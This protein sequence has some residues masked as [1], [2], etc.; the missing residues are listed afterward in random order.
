MPEGLSPEQAAFWQAFCQSPGAPVDAARRFHSAFGIGSGSDAGAEAVVSGRKTATSALPSEFLPGKPPVAGSLSLL[1]ASGNRP[2]AIVETV[3]I[4]PLSLDEMDGDFI[5]A[6]GEWEDATA[7][8]QGML[9]WYRSV[10][11]G[12]T[13]KTKL[14]AERFR[15][16]WTK[17]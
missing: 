14:L 11:P 9:D 13:P 6:Y 1:Y 5:R 12:F 4:T 17:G 16:V 2:V 7:F 8:R 3:S 15:V 10:D